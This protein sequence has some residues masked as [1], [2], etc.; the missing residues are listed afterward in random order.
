MAATLI[1]TFIP[2][3]TTAFAAAVAAPMV[4]S[5]AAGTM[6]L[7]LVG[8]KLL[9]ARGRVACV[10]AGDVAVALAVGLV[11]LGAGVTN[12]LRR[13]GE[14]SLAGFRFAVQRLA[15]VAHAQH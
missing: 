14:F 8:F 10:R 3:L 1:V 15:H 7:G 12:A 9:A 6:W 5:L 4:I 2:I 13:P 11:A